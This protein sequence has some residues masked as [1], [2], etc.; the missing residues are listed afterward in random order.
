MSIVRFNP[1]NEVFNLQHEMNRLFD[2]LVPATRRQ[3][4]PEAEGAV[5]RP[6][7]DIHEDENNYTIDVE[8]P[9]LAREDVKINFQDD[10]LT[11]SGERR[12]SYE[13]RN[14]E[15]GNGNGNGVHAK[16]RSCRRMER[17]YGRFFRSFTLPTTVNPDGIRAKF[18]N[19]ILTV[20]VPKAEAVKP[21][22]IEIG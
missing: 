19:G 4:D 9:G 13:K 6:V 21:R 8:L 15:N 22:Q 5:W 12:Y 18:E 11:I 2:N 20:T 14:E 17:F 1:L 16:E 10:T 7:V 3:V